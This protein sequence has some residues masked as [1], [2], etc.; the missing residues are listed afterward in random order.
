VS[1][2]DIEFIRRHP[3]AVLGFRRTTGNRQ[4]L[5]KWETQ[6][7]LRPLR[8]PFFKNFAECP[9]FQT[10]TI[11]EYQEPHCRENSAV[12]NQERP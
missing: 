10:G 11:S 4:A 3:L 6:F 1:R 5:S 9:I 2:S 12:L 8:R 7:E